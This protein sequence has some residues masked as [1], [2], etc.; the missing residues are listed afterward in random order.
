VCVF[1]GWE[2][3]KG[4]RGMSVV[5][6]YVPSFGTIDTSVLICETEYHMKLLHVPNFPA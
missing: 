5:K 4:F 1:F 2:E 6:A 3:G